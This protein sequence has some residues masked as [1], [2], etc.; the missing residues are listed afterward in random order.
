MKSYYLTV[1][2][3]FKTWWKIFACEHTKGELRSQ[4]N[5]GAIYYCHDCGAEIVCADYWKEW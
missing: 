2:A 4:D 3:A 1:K 5:R